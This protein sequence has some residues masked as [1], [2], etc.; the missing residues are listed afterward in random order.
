MTNSLE[1][2]AGLQDN[3]VTITLVVIVA[4]VVCVLTCMLFWRFIPANSQQIVVFDVHKYV[5]AQRHILGKITGEV[6]LDGVSL[7]TSSSS[8]LNKI[9]REVVS[10]NT[11]ILVKSAVVNNLHLD[12]T[13]DVLKVLGLPTEGFESIDI[14]KI[15][16]RFSM[17]PGL[18]GHK[19]KK[20]NSI[21]DTKIDLI[22]GLMP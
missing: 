20:T 15:S 11:V 14:N 18:L 8:N 1:E 7:V 17:D 5:N 22:K 16:K 21:E 19:N 3:G 10:Q 2:T 4:V 6:D 9:L 13:D 12:I